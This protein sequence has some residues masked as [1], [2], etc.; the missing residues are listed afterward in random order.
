[1]TC[2]IAAN[3]NRKC[4]FTNC[5]F[6]ILLAYFSQM[7]RQAR[8]PII[9]IILPTASFCTDPGI[10]LFGGRNPPPTKAG[11]KY[12]VGDQIILTCNPGFVHLGSVSRRCLPTGKWTG[13]NTYCKGTNHSQRT[14]IKTHDSLQILQGSI[15]GTIGLREAS[16]AHEQQIREPCYRDGTNSRNNIKHH[17]GSFKNN[18]NKLLKAI[19]ISHVLFFLKGNVFSIIDNQCIR[20]PINLYQQLGCNNERQ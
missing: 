6:V 15:S 20:A 14:Q 13:S 18:C 8:F 1:M 17:S 3:N 2:W 19:K 12:N 10:P 7:F 5:C 9:V 4:I 11:A 16:I